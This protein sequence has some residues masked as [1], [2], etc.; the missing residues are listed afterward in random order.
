MSAEAVRRIL[1]VEDEAI[2]AIDTSRRVTSFGYSVSVA[3]HGEAAIQ[4]VDDAH[5]NGAPFDLLLM[6]IDLGAGIDGTET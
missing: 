1:L 5:A 2:V 4:A 3:H 6:D